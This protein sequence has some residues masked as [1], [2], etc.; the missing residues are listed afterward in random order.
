MKIISSLCIKAEQAVFEMVRQRRLSQLSGKTNSGHQLDVGMTG[1]F[2]QQQPRFQKQPNNPHIHISQASL[3]SNLKENVSSFL[4]AKR[5]S[6]VSIGPI[7]LPV[8]KSSSLKF[9]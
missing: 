4:T 2:M 1:G 7:V 8:I 6:S 9:C 5:N 3:T